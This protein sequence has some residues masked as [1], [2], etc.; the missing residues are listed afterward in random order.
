MTFETLIVE[1]EGPVTVIR[2]N[3]PDALNALNSVLLKELGDALDLISADETV[4]CVVL[5]GSDRAFAAGADI[6]EMADKSYADMFKSDM[7]GAIARKFD[8][9][10]KP[11]IAAVS[12]AAVGT[13]LGSF[14]G[15]GIGSS[16]G[17]GVGDA[18]ANAV[19]GAVGSVVGI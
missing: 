12:G 3:R 4:R 19:G 8:A 13:L 5:T 18:V 9:F 2:L 15:S 1:T 16:D 10:R 7:F 6:K 11:V 17:C 14:V